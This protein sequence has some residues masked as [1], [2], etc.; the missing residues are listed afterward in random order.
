MERLSP[1]G[2]A[3]VLRVPLLPGEAVLTADLAVKDGAVAV[4]LPPGAATLSWHSTLEQRPA[5]SLTAPS[6]ASWVERWVLD[7]GPMWHVQLGGIAPVHPG[8]PAE[9][10]QPIWLPWPGE[11]VSVQVTRP[12]GIGG[13]TLTL[14][15]AREEVRPGLRATEVSLD[16]AFRTSRGGQHAL[17]LPPGVELLGVA[18]NGQPQP[19]RLE[20]DRLLVTLAPPASRVA[21]RWR[22]PR[23]ISTAFR[24]SPV[25]VGAAGANVDVVICAAVRPL[26]AL[27]RRADL[28]TGGALL[29]RAAGG[30]ARRP[31]ALPGAAH[32]LGLGAW[33]LLAIGLTQV[34]VPRR[35]W[36][37][38]GSSRSAGA[39][40]S[41]PGCGRGGCST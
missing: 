16:L 31:G 3:V 11:S 27:A 30:G 10:H 35:R 17:A 18:V 6:T 7:A 12:E 29:E 15:S 24:P 25:D 2:S 32:P 36:W 13:G 34:S 28:R 41:E 40:R 19:A 39:A 23:G 22:E 26:G 8:G 37:W 1:A 33:M 4:N 9:S 14:D 5:L 21:V 38:S 20:G